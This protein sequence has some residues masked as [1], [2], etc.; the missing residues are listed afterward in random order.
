MTS[1]PR[2]A[3]LNINLEAAEEFF[4]E[5]MVNGFA[6]GVKPQQN[7]PFPGSYTHQYA[8]G[9]LS[10]I[11]TWLVNPHT[12]STA[13]MTTILWNALPIWFMQYHGWYHTDAIS[14]LQ[15]ALKSAYVEKRFRGGRGSA[16]FDTPFY[17]YT[18]DFR[19]DDFRSFSG[20]E[21][22]VTRYTNQ[23]AGT[24]KYTGGWLLNH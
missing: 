7:K 21:R 6:S 1:N 18:N 10:L 22:I 19:D 16:I 12:F 13:G 8:R 3:V 9:Q 14:T 11:D 17:R 2:P 20:E 4:F 24:H 5:G 15:D 23:E